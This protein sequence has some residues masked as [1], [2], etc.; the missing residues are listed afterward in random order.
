MKYYKVVKENN[1]GDLVS[2]HDGYLLTSAI[3]YKVGEW[4]VPV[5]KDSK[6]FIF[7]N[8]VDALMFYCASPSRIYECDAADVSKPPTKVLSLDSIHRNS[9]LSD[10]W[11]NEWSVDEVYKNTNVQGA[12]VASAVKLTK[13]IFSYKEPKIYYKG[14]LRDGLRLVSPYARTKIVYS[15]GGWTVPEI[16]G[17]KIFIFDS[18]E[19]ASGF[20]SYLRFQAVEIWSCFAANVEKSPNDLIFEFSLNE[21]NVEAF[22]ANSG[23]VGVGMHPTGG[24][25]VCDA[26]S[27]KEKVN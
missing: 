14:L 1:S 16:K 7:D 27:L 24:T 10:F 18:L 5:V 12:L 6:V 17:S 19:R 22:W 23:A 9:L 21:S 25:V 26:I 13:E 20:F 4:T 15:L 2:I 8:I 11:V 3:K